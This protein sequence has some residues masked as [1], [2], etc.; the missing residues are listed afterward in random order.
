MVRKIVA[1]LT[2]IVWFTVVHAQTY[3][4]V[5]DSS[6]IDFSIKNLGIKVKG[7]F[8][9]L[10]GTIA[11]DPVQPEKSTFEVLVD[12]ASVNTGNEKRDDHL[13]QEVFLDVKNYPHIKFV[14][15][16]VTAGR[17]AG[18]F[19]MEGTLTIKGISLPL[20][21]PFTV[22]PTTDGY[23]M[24][25]KFGTRRKPFTVGRTSTI[26]DKLTV[27]LKVLTKKV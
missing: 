12:A 20:S 26:S 8:T 1:L 21:F 27:F 6:R 5:S 7:S 3:V 23:W 22:T 25:G 2:G 14:S 18:T 17:K 15:T 4:P 24:E 19:F 16:K 13:R 11:F 10:Q 9:R